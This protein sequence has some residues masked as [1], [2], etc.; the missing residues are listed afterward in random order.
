M[1]YTRELYVG[2]TLGE[3]MERL[4]REPNCNIERDCPQFD[5]EVTFPDGR[6]VA[7]QVVSPNDPA[8]ES[9]WTQGVLFDK[10]GTELAC[11]DVGESFADEYCLPYGDDEYVVEVVVTPTG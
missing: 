5:E 2:R 7:I 6:R 11:T 8:S 1:K 9:C 3:E 4:C 10:N